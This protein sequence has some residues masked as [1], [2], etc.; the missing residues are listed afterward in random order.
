M[1]ARSARFFAEA[2]ALREHLSK[3]SRFNIKT[4]CAWDNSPSTFFAFSSMSSEV[5]S[6]WMS[7]GWS[8]RL[9]GLRTDRDW[10]PPDPRSGAAMRASAVRRGMVCFKLWRMISLATS[11]HLSR[12]GCIKCVRWFTGTRLGEMEESKDSSSY[13]GRTDLRRLQESC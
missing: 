4:T 7:S 13:D 6:V 9:G 12:G 10:R 11:G 8:L 1:D 2:F 3:Y 5:N